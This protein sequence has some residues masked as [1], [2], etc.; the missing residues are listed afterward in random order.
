VQSLGIPRHQQ[1]VEKEG[2]KP[3]RFLKTHSQDRIAL[4]Y[5]IDG[6]PPTINTSMQCFQNQ[7]RQNWSIQNP[8]QVT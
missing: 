8:S 3:N 1:L 6:E 4:T 5:H 7:I 2:Q